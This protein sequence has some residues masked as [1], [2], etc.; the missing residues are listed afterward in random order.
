MTTSFWCERSSRDTPTPVPSTATRTGLTGSL[1]MCSGDTAL[2]VCTTSSQTLRRWT[3]IPEQLCLWDFMWLITR[4]EFNLKIGQHIKSKMNF[5]CTHPEKK[6]KENKSLNKG[7]VHKNSTL[8]SDTVNSLWG[9]RRLGFG[10]LFFVLSYSLFLSFYPI[11][12]LFLLLVF[13]FIYSI[14]IYVYTNISIYTIY[15]HIQCI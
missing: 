9:T 15:V 10:L 11:I 14:Y 12:F 13:L 8:V 2:L 5:F 6:K 1:W 3:L 7:R 4:V